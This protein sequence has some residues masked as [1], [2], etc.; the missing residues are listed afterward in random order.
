MRLKLS[1]IEKF[2]S[3]VLVLIFISCEN[4]EP[5]SLPEADRTPPSVVIIHPLENSTVSGMV[6]LQIHATDNDKVDSVLIIINNENIGV[7]KNNKNDLFEYKWNTLEYEDDLFYALSFLAFD[8]KENSYRTYPILVKI[9]NDDDIPPNIKIE[10]PYMGAVISGV[11]PIILSASD[12][13]SIEYVSIYVNNILQGYVTDSPYVFTW[14]TNLIE[15]GQYSIHAIATDMSKNST[16]LSP[17]VVNALNGN[18][19]DNAPPTGAIMFPASGI[20]VSGEVVIS[21]IAADNSGNPVKVDFGINGTS[22]FVDNSEPYEYLWDTTDETEDQEQIITITLE[23][24][25]GNKS[26]LNPITVTVDNQSENGK[27]PIMNILSPS[28]GETISGTITINVSSDAQSEMDYVEFTINGVSSFVDLASPFSFNWDSENVSDDNFYIIGAIGYNSAGQSGI[29]SPITV[30]V[31][32]Y[33]NFPPTGQIIY[34]YPGQTVYDTVNIEISALDNIGIQSVEILIN[35]NTLATITEPP[36]FFSWNTLDEEDD[37]NYIIGASLTDLSNNIFIVPSIWVHV[38]NRDS[39]PP[40]GVITNPISGQTVDGIVNFTVIAYDDSGIS[41]VEFFINGE[42]VLIDDQSEFI[43]NWD[44]TSLNNNSQHS[45][46]AKITDFSN[47]ISLV[48][49]VLVTVNN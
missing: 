10:N 16:K 9:D 35:N 46:S 2:L 12:N 40:N 47:N 48:Q 4:Q 31:D 14:N 20:N 19:N 8:R 27:P 23:D 6:N 5:I 38:N 34:P 43:F 26:I 33:D 37:Q 18:I 17:I 29:A 24:P 39:N 15:D 1:C 11:V 30:Y 21:V 28:S 22:M 36:Y 3:C 44:T 49:P 45:L 7:I 32:N 41:S 25:S 42:S 13:D